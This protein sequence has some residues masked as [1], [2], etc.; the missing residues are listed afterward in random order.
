MTHLLALIRA[1]NNRKDCLMVLSA[2]ART[3]HG[4][5]RDGPRHGAGATPPLH[6][7]R[8]SA[9]GARTVRD[10]VEGLLRSRPRSHLREGPHWGGE[11][12]GC[13]LAS[14]CHPRRL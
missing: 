8:R 12:V 6:T 3:V 4:Q 1:P 7:S 10:G 2:E 11:I 5:G 13:V 14:T 9:S